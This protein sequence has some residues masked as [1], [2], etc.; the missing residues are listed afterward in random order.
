MAHGIQQVLTQ[1]YLN[2]AWIPCGTF[3]TDPPIWEPLVLFFV[4][5]WQSYK[6]ERCVLINFRSWSHVIVLGHHPHVEAIPEEYFL[7]AITF[8]NQIER[9][10]R[11]ASPP[12]KIHGQKN[13]KV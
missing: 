1:N 12:W 6:R 8:L 10:Q 4:L 7:G 3:F 9:G 5:G 11:V 2:N 13:I